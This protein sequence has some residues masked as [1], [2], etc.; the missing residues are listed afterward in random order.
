MK[1]TVAELTDGFYNELRYNSAAEPYVNDCVREV[2]LLLGK[3][4]IDVNSTNV[5]DATVENAIRAFQDMIGMPVTGILNN[6]TLQAMIYYTD[7]KMDDSIEEDMDEESETDTKK[8]DSPHYNP[9][10]D[11]DKFKQHR[12]NHK[13]IKIIFG[14]NSIVKT[15]KDVFMRSVTVE[16][17]TSGNPISEIYEFVAR[18]IKESDEISD[19]IKYNGEEIYAPSDIK[20][21]FNFHELNND[22]TT[23]ISDTKPEIEQ[24]DNNTKSD[25]ELRDKLY[26]EYLLNSK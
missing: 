4:G 13:D 12:Q 10:F 1:Q 3:C 20:Y 21:I 23:T 5:Y 24:I 6:N 8:S 25:Q 15:I 18:D 16:V 17:D 19:I 22:N 26:N 11:T 14:N 7:K 2:C 9:F